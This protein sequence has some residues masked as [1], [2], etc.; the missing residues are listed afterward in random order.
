[1]LE[2]KQQKPNYKTISNHINQVKNSPTQAKK[3]TECKKKQLTIFTHT[4]QK[5]LI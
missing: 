4:K 3:R 2:L 5:K 1:M